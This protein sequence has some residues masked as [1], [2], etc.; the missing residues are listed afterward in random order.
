MQPPG[1]SSR[2]SPDLSEDIQEVTAIF[3]RILI[4]K[5]P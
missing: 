3:N 2:S 4:G 5:S 1:I